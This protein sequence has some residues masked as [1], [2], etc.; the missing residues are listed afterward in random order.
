MNHE[1]KLDDMESGKRVGLGRRGGG[2]KW[3]SKR[4][5]CGGSGGGWVSRRRRCSGGGG[6]W[7]SRRWRYNKDEVTIYGVSL[8]GISCPFYCEGGVG[9]PFLEASDS[10]ATA[11]CLGLMEWSAK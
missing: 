4:W 11:G 5:R 2:N 8:G 7:V 3:V 9:V 6:G 10:R 1:T